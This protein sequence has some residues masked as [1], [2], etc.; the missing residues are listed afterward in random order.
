[1]KNAEMG[2]FLEP[3]IILQEA[4]L[5]SG[6][7][8]AD[9]GCG[10]GYFSIAAAVKVGEGGEVFSLDVLPSALESVASRAKISGLT[11]IATSRV[12]LEK[13]NGSKLGSASVDWVLIK[14]MLFQNDRK[15]IILNEAFRILRPGGKVLIV[16]WNDQDAGVGPD[17]K[18]RIGKKALNE[19]A[20]QAKFSVEKEMSAG[21]FHYAIVA[22]VLK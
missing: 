14:D 12:N 11:N 13:E 1:M 5:K 7:K 20:K 21:D 19:L 3:E 18:L 17:K 2:S 9:F 4:G 10:S 15:E 8:V 22:G 16:E 6:D